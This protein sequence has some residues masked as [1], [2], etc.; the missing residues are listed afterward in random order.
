MINPEEG[1]WGPGPWE[2]YPEMGLIWPLM[3]T[4]R[5]CLCF[6]SDSLSTHIHSVLPEVAMALGACLGVAVSSRVEEG[7]QG[8]RDTGLCSGGALGLEMRMDSA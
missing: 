5:A 8:Q 2:E 3:Q 4:P 1:I 7:T 6:S